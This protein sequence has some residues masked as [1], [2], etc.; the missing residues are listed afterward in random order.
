MAQRL[1]ELVKNKDDQAKEYFDF[2]RSSV[3]DGSYFKDAMNWYFFRYINPICDRTLLI[4]GS[5]IAAVVLFFLVGMI[6]S[7]FP[8]VQRVPIFIQAKDQSL[9]FPHLVELK[10][11]KN[12]PN[13]DPEAR[14]LDE[15]I[16]KYLIINYVKN[17]EEF[18]YSK[19]RIED[20]NKKFNHIR[21]T[22]SVNEYQAFQAFM[23]KNN[24]TS[25]LNQFGKKVTKT[26]KIESLHFIRK[27][28]KNFA[29]KAMD[30]LTN[31]IPTEAEIRFVAITKDF[32]SGIMQQENEK[33]IAKVN[34][35]FA[36]AASNDKSKNLDFTVNG[37]KLF[38]IK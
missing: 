31:K 24:P 5:I 13:Y 14:S 35:N 7:A 18:D 17:R 36:G 34:F 8:L 2:I 4:F 30:Y 19:A 9:Y 16:S 21:N 25:P 10:P 22:S 11:K 32:S 29:D 23:D 33:Y 3:K 15:M 26:I 12:S 27:E 1:E 20:F 37:Y 28:P 6:Q 38:K